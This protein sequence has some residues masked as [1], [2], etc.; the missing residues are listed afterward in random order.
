MMLAGE[1]QRVHRF[2]DALMEIHLRN[3]ERFLGAV[4]SHIDVIVFGDD[5]GA[6]NGP[7]ISPRMYREFFK[8]RHAMHVGARQAAG[9]REGH[10]A[11]LRG[12]APTAARPDRRRAG[13]HQPGADQLPGHGSRRAEARFRQGPDVLGRRLRHAGSSAAAARPTK[14]ANTC[15]INAK[16]WRPAADSSSS[17]CTTLWPMCPRRTSSRCTTRCGSRHKRGGEDISG[18][19][20]MERAG[21]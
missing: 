7:Q 10:A 8:P 3:L 2:L 9:Q 12:G 18:G 13:R 11:L 17:K 16:C 14:C 4:G 19:A 21:L 5:L 6:Q 20:K 1:P 15:C